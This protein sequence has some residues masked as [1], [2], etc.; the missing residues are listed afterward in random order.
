M[1]RNFFKFPVFFPIIWSNWDY[2]IIF[3]LEFERLV[4][5]GGTS[6]Q[7]PACPCRRHKKH[8]FDLRVGKIPWR[9]A[10]QLMPVLLPGECHRQ[11]SL[12]GY[13]PWDHR[14]GH[15][16][17]GLA[18]MHWRMYR[19]ALLL[20]NIKYK[21]NFMSQVITVSHYNCSYEIRALLGRMT[22]YYPCHASAIAGHQAP[23]K[24]TCPHACSWKSQ[25]VSRRFVH[26]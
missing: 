25:W 21:Q 22:F 6:D 3:G 11:R 20:N 5:L 8:G 19:R 17:S 15:N 26:Y 12:A 23:L 1:S 2:H 24:F 18:C 10:W 14:V 9:R 4:F 7:E 16:W 13:R